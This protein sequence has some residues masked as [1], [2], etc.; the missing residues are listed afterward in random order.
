MRIRARLGARSDY[1]LMRECLRLQI[2]QLDEIYAL[3]DRLQ[4]RA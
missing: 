1:D 3:A 4:R 2:V